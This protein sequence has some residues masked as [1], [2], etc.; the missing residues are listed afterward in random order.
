M[1]ASLQHELDS[2][3]TAEAAA[4][5]E[6]GLSVRTAATRGAVGGGA[7]LQRIALNVLLRWAMVKLCSA[8]HI[9]ALLSSELGQ[10]AGAFT[11]GTLCGIAARTLSSQL[12]SLAKTAR[13]PRSRR[14]NQVPFSAVRKA[15][16]VPSLTRAFGLGAV[17]TATMNAI[18]GAEASLHASAAL[19]DGA[20]LLGGL[21]AGALTAAASRPVDAVLSSIRCR[22]KDATRGDN[23]AAAARLLLAADVAAFIALEAACGKLGLDPVSAV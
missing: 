8:E 23:P 7:S 18:S 12:A 9:D 16:P 17:Q 19:S 11:M 15:A 5:A 2:V 21:A 3:V 20:M 22:L 1:S 13:T 4:A 6:A 14:N 10:F